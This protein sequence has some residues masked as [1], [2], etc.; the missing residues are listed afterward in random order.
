[1]EKSIGVVLGHRTFHRTNRGTHPKAGVRGKSTP[2]PL[3]LAGTFFFIVL[4]PSCGGVSYALPFSNPSVL[5]PVVTVRFKNR[6]VQSLICIYA[7]WL[8]P[9]RQMR[10]TRLSAARSETAA[11][12]LGEF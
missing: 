9:P 2:L 6:P 4:A 12:P 7:G 11:L 3:F 1:M 10:T 5:R 8:A